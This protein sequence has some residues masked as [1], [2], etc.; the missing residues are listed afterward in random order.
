MFEFEFRIV[1]FSSRF[2]LAEKFNIHKVQS[3]PYYAM[4][5]VSLQVACGLTR[6]QI[7][8]CWHVIG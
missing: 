6:F 1:S 8:L 4:P 2:Q 5:Y 7:C 3:L